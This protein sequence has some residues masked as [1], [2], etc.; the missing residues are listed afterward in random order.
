MNKY[1]ILLLILIN[2]LIISSQD[3]IPPM[4]ND[5]LICPY[6]AT[7]PIYKRGKE[8]LNIDIKNNLTYPKS[9]LKDSIQ[10]K[11]Y[12]SY[13]IDTLGKINNPFIIKGIREDLNK[14]S[15][16]VIKLLGDWSP[17][18]ENGKK[19]PVRYILPLN[20]KINHSL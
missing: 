5:L 15:L 3:E 19:V 12:V 2:C 14:E 16:R 8:Q 9:A 13:T 4:D 10:G 18:I 17:A 20:F 7:K 11:V 6:S 1:L